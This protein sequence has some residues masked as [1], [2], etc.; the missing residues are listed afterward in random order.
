MIDNGAL[1]LPTLA[2]ADAVADEWRAQGDE[3]DPRAMPLTGLANAAIDRVAPDPVG[4]AAPLAAYGESDVLC[5]RAEGPAELVAEQAT[6][7]EPL[8][9]WARTGRLRR[10]AVSAVVMTRSA[11][12]TQRASATGHSSRAAADTAS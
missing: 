10:G 6:A 5:Y 8:L 2:L 4:F 3:I 7:W 11:I 1:I 12:C 9:A